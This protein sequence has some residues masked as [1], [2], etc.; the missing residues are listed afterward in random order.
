M[1]KYS[2]IIV[3][4]VFTMVIFAGSAFS[5]NYGYGKRDGSG[6]CRSFGSGQGSGRGL[7]AQWANLSEDQ[8]AQI[9][10]LHQKFIDDTAEKRSAKIAKHH[11]I[12]ILMETSSPDRERLILLAGEL[13]DL[14]KDLMTKRI[15]FALE[16]KKIAPELNIS[17]GFHKFGMFGR[18][19]LYKGFRMGRA[20]C[21]LLE[22]TSNTSNQ[23]DN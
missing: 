20:G 7:A 19:D 18:N 21:P 12:R 15:D 14:K 8:K 23:T 5:G 10:A 2:L 22:Q 17:T 3:A 9:N 16:A 4:V 11:E 6:L 1:K 13:G